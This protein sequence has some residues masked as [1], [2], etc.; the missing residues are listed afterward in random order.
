MIGRCDHCTW[1]FRFVAGRDGEVG[2]C[3]HCGKNTLLSGHPEQIPI[4]DRFSMDGMALLAAGII[5]GSLLL[6]AGYYAKDGKWWYFG[7][8]VAVVFGGWV[9]MELF[10]ALAEIIRL[11]RK[12]DK[13][14]KSCPIKQ[15]SDGEPHSK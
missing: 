4:A 7:I 1:T 6:P 9:L 13:K 14:T 2:P 11:L 3:P 12:I 10:N 5:G 15:P 8:A